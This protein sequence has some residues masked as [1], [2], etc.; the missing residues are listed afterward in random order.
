MACG[1]NRRS[2]VAGATSGSSIIG[3]VLL[4]KCPLCLAIWL[5]MIGMSGISAGYI[6]AFLVSLLLLMIAVSGVQLIFIRRSYVV[7]LLAAL[8]ASFIIRRISPSPLFSLIA[9]V[10][11]V[12]VIYSALYLARSRQGPS[13]CQ[14]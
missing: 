12:I 10:G 5:S 13:S 14:V 3:L 11:T 1:G 8:V 6:E 4:P 7:A 2:L 9:S